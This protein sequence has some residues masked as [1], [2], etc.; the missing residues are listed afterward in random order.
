MAVAMV[1]NCYRCPTHPSQNGN[2]WEECKE[3]LNEWNHTPLHPYLTTTIGDAYPLR[4]H[5][6]EPKH[7]LY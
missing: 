1:D 7:V 5:G 3:R 6:G 2:H 4:S